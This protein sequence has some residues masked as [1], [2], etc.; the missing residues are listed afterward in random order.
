MHSSLLK[1][2]EL[3]SDLNAATAAM[4]ASSDVNTNRLS[5]GTADDDLEAMFMG[6][7]SSRSQAVNKHRE[8]LRKLEQ[9]KRQQKEVRLCLG[10]CMK[11]PYID[12]A[13]FC[14]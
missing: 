13:S 7:T 4:S 10:N 2:N 6:S 14:E 11:I 12:I 5:G 1:V 9:E 8:H 3:K